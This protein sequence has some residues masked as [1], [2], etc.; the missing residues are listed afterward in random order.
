MARL[1]SDK[2]FLTAPF[3]IAGVLRYLQITLVEH[4]SGSPTRL[5]VSD[6]FLLIS[7]FGWLGT[8]AWL[9]YG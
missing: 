6:P 1:G 8:F 9:I 5:A 7:I 2:L 4:R 3:V